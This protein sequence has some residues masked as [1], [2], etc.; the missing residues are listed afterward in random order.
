MFFNLVLCIVHS[1]LHSP[2]VPLL[3]SVPSLR[4]SV[5]SMALCPLH[6]TLSPLWP[7]ASPTALCP[8]YDPLSLYGSL[9]LNGPL[10]LI[11]PSVPSKARSPLGP[12]SPLWTFLLTFSRNDDV[13][14]QFCE[15]CFAET[16]HFVKERNERND[17]SLYAKRSMKCFAIRISSKLWIVEGK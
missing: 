4:S 5:P 2:Y 3:H 7:S 14:A 12:L 8:P 13:V 6:G 1:E 10:T 15:T 17:P 9:P 11:R 16:D